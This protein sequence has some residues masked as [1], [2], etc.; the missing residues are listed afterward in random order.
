MEHSIAN[1]AH[2]SIGEDCWPRHI[3]Q[4]HVEW[5]PRAKKFGDAGIRGER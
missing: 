4:L 3:E 1:G 2:I 5:L